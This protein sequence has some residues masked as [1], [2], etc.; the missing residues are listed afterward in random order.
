MAASKQRFRR[1]ERRDAL[2]FARRSSH[3]PD[4]HDTL[5]LQDTICRE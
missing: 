4:S 3:N 1:Y 5:G 2:A